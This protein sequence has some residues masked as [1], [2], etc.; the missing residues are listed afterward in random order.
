[1]GLEVAIARRDEWISGHIENAELHAEPSN[2]TFRGRGKHAA[3]G[4]RSAHLLRCQFQKQILWDRWGDVSRLDGSSKPALMR[5]RPR[6]DWIRNQ[7]VAYGKGVWPWD[8]IP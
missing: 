7:T 5:Q 2:L 4:R 6:S 1:M 8:G 3:A